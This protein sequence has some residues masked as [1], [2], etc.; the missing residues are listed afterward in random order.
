[1]SS[2][3]PVLTLPFEI[4]SAIFLDCLPRSSYS[5]ADSDNP[6]RL[7][8]SQDEA[9]VLLTRIC[10]DWRTIAISTPNLWT[11]LQIELDSDDGPGHI[12]STWVSLADIWLCRSQ[13]QPLS[14]FIS[15]LSYTDPD[16]ALVDVI[17][18]H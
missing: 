3:Y 5:G 16:D 9:P 18:R 6:M 12:N 11:H 14:V 17:D 10:R 8:P 2:V 1:K 13:N 7:Y 4:T 15:N